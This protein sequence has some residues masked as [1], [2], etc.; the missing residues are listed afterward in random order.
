MENTAP[1]KAWETPRV[2]VLGAE[3][4]QSVLSK[5]ATEHTAHKIIYNPHSCAPTSGGK[6]L[7]QSITTSVFGYVVGAGGS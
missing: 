4:T 5:G 7:C 3:G 6:I 1:R 2:F